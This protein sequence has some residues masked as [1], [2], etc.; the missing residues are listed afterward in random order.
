MS[1]LIAVAITVSACNIVSE[2]SEEVTKA[3]TVRSHS[4]N[5]YHLDE[6][7]YGA[8]K[9]GFGSFEADVWYQP[10]ISNEVLIGHDLWELNKDKTFEGMYIEPLVEYVESMGSTFYDNW[11]YSVVLLID[12]KSGGLN[13]WRE[14]EKVLERYPE[15]FTRYDN[16]TVYQGP[17]T[18]IISG[19]RPIDE[20]ES[21]DLRYSFVDGRINNVDEDL[22]PSTLMPLISN[23]F[24]YFDK[25][26][27]DNYK[28]EGPWPQSALDEL[29][30]I[31][32][33]AHANN[34]KIRFWATPEKIDDVEFNTYI[35]QGL[36]EGDVDFI[37]T[38]L[39]N[40]LHTWLLDNDPT[41][42]IPSVDWL[43]H[44]E[45]EKM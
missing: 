12:I 32:D 11:D 7:F 38:D 31:T 33:V 10:L 2:D 1:C 18:A 20:M 25:P 29:I 27:F 44:G 40:E 45:W 23:N 36:V 21:M 15:V 6:P 43:E 5:D 39:Q 35:W 26:E 4:H 24:N 16:G 8:M 9:K 22:Y 17:V 34:Q 13:T 42:A 19:N 41:P 14:V 37:N 28:G 30:R 3:L